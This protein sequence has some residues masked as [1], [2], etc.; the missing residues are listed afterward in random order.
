MSRLLQRLYTVYA[1]F[2]DGVVR[3]HGARRDAISALGL[4]EGD[5]VIIPGAGTG[6]DLRHLPAGVEAVAGD[7]STGMLRR[8]RQEAREVRAQVEVARMDALQTD[9]P[10]GSFDAALLHL[11]VAVVPDPGACLQEAVRLVRPGGRISILDKFA[12]DGRPVA[13]WRRAL[14]PLTRRVATS[15]VCRLEDLLPGLPVEVRSREPAAFGGFFE[16]ILLQRR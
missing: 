7:L 3:M 9:L 8:L 2:Y 4:S 16:R 1:P 10:E 6:A 13:L 11:V 5:R 14:D 12:P 15:I